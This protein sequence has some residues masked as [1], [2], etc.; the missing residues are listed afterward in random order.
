M[1]APDLIDLRDRILAEQNEQA[2]ADGLD[3]SFFRDDDDHGPG[4]DGPYNCV[5]GAV[6]S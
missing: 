3:L 6:G 2:R 4:C 1:T 5:C